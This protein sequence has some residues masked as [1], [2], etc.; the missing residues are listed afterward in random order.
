VEE[1]KRVNIQLLTE[2]VWSATLA[3]GFM[4]QPNVP[5]VMIKLPP[6]ATREV[7]YFVRR[8]TLLATD[9]NQMSGWQETI[10]AYLMRNS[11]D[12]SLYFNLPHDRVV[13]MGVRLDL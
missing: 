4:E 11:Q 10:F 12:I 6:E 3:C 9:S 5:D 2:G 1:E 8:E 13:E 7:T